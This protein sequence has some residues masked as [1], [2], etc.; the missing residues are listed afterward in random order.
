[1]ALSVA[2][3]PLTDLGA[4]PGGIHN[5]AF[6]ISPA[7]SIYGTPG[8]VPGGLP[9]VGEGGHGPGGDK[10]VGVGNG[11]GKPGGGGNDSSAAGP[12]TNSGVSISGNAGSPG[13]SAGTLPPLKPEDLVYQVKP[14]TPKARA[15]SMVVSAGS[16]GGGGLR[17][18]GVLHSDRIYT[19]YF[20]MPGK[21]WILQYC[22]HDPP[23]QT[24]PNSRVVQIQMRPPLIPPAVIDQFDFHRAPADPA[25]ADSMIILH[26]T[27]HEDGSVGDLT[28]LQGADPTNNAA[29]MA[30][31]RHWKFKPA[32]R[33]GTPVALEILMGIP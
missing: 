33:S 6:S 20:S 27:I 17:M 1:M 25:P 3:T 8:G 24:D 15:P 18:Y 11:V 22:A 31:L 5:G 32:L 28:V 29:A 14:E 10:S 7:G 23:P 13:V 21:N 12:S 4:I 19:I 30:A 2:P 26:G 16:A 9:D